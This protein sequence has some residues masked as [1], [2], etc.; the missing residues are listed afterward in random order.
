MKIA[1]AL[2]AAASAF[3]TAMDG[4]TAVKYDINDAVRREAG[5]D[6]HDLEIAREAAA[7]A[8]RQAADRE[9]T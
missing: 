9:P 7:L 6:S 4:G 8:R 1:R 3:R 2:D 5:F